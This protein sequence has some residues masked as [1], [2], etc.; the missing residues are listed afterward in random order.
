MRSAIGLLCAAAILLPLPASSQEAPV[1]VVTP[2][3]SVALQ[4]VPPIPAAYAEAMNRYAD[5]RTAHLVAWHPV[6][7]EMLIATR[8]GNTFQLHRVT[9]PGGERTQVTFD[10]AGVAGTGLGASA[11]FEPGSDHILYLRDVSPGK[12]L[13]QYFHFDPSVDK[14]PTMLTD[15]A[16]RS[17]EGAW[18]RDGRRFA[19]TSNK[20]AVDDFDLYVM[21]PHDPSSLR[22]AAELKGMNE[23][24]EWAPDGKSVLVRE[25]LSAAESK[26]WI[27]PVDGGEKRQARPPTR[28][29]S[30]TTP[31]SSPATAGPPS[32]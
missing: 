2:P 16:S 14:T 21:A 24:L 12:G 10:E 17:F 30:R 23:V 19:W 1:P 28:S 20:R 26:L 15:G 5:Y 31:P 3:A 9:S 7:R 18:S 8:F 11:W 32:S 22:L 4:G 13:R 29:R 27:V 25:E 6:R